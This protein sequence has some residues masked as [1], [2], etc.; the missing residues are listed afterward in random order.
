MIYF[1]FP[2]GGEAAPGSAGWDAWIFGLAPGASIQGAFGGGFMK[3]FVGAGETW[4]P[5][6]F[7]LDRDSASIID[8]L[9]PILNAEDPNLTPFAARGGKLILV[10]GW[11]DAAIPAQGTIDY[12]ENVRS[13]VGADRADEFTRL[14]LVPGMHHCGG[15]TGPSDLG[16]AGT[17]RLPR[18]PVSDLS[19]ALEEWVELGREPGAIVARQ[20]SAPGGLVT[21]EPVRTGLICPYPQ[22]AVLN[23]GGSM[24]NADDYSCARE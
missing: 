19:A 7:D 10:H 18:D 4:T 5:S 22:R 13:E 24:T 1:G 9:G 20:A 23:S 8:N 12:Y 2:P 11:S 17:P 21:S 16:G 6:E 14:Y 3:Y 15:G